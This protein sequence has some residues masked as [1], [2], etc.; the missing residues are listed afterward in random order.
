MTLTGYI[1]TFILG[2]SSKKKQLEVAFA[3][4]LDCVKLS[5]INYACLMQMQGVPLLFLE[6]Q[7]KRGLPTF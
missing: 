4:D 1:E 7:L 3:V 6:C 5:R 2:H